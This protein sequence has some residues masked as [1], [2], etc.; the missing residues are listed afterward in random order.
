MQ[1][2]ELS[3]NATLEDYNYE[4][5]SLT[6]F[7]NAMQRKKFPFSD[8]MKRVERRNRLINERYIRFKTSHL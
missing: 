4:I 7:I 8:I 1:E 5:K 2:F 6:K 3:N